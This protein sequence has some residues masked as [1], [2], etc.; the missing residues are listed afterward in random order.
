[1]ILFFDEV[2]AK[3]VEWAK[4]RKCELAKER[5][6]SNQ[7]PMITFFSCNRSQLL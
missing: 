6:T 7:F 2:V 5:T 1:M 4:T 3:K